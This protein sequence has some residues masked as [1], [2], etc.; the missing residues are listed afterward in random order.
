MGV[1]LLDGE[2]LRFDEADASLV[3]KG[4][5][6]AGSSGG[7]AVGFAPGVTPTSG[8]KLVEWSASGTVPAHR[9]ALSGGLATGWALAKEQDALRIYK[10]PDPGEDVFSVPRSGVRF[11]PDMDIVSW[12]GG[13][14]DGIDLQEFLE[15]DGW[16]GLPRYLSYALG[17]DADYDTTVKTEIAIVDGRVVITPSRGAPEIPGVVL[18]TTLYGAGDLSGNLPIVDVFRGRSFSIDQFEGSAK[19]FYKLEVTIDAQ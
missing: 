3:L 6:A 19:G 7:V 5:V 11:K 13:Y 14:F 2:K 1:S 4:H 18:V 15:E 17:I 16:N 12:M 8:Q 9:F 10:M